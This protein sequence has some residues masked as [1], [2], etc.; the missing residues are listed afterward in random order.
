MERGG[1]RQTHAKTRHK[2][3]G[4]AGTPCSPLFSRRGDDRRVF[5]FPPRLAR[6]HVQCHGRALGDNRVA[7]RERGGQRSGGSRGAERAERLRGLVP[8]HPVLPG[9]RQ[10]VPQG[11]EG[12]RGLEL[13]QDVRHL[14]L[15]EGGGGRARRAQRGTQ[16]SDGGLPSVVAQRKQGAVPVEDGGSVVEEGGGERLQGGARA[17][18]RR[19]VDREEARVGARGGGGVAAVAVTVP[20]LQPRRA[21]EGEAA[22]FGDF[23]RRVR[24]KLL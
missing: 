21:S 17:R 6:Q 23:A 12:C 10:R 22:G 13:A 9:V 14:V 4:A 5:E 15:K 7:V 8:H 3:I 11:W 1:G 20:G 24:G 16:R 18:G 2:R 19:G